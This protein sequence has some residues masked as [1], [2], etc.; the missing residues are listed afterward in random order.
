[1]SGEGTIEF[2]LC[3]DRKIRGL[4]SG[5][6]A[7]IQ[8]A[9]APGSSEQTGTVLFCLLPPV[10]R[11]P[12]QQP[13]SPALL[14]L[15]PPGDTLDDRIAALSADARD[16]FELLYKP[17]ME[18][19]DHRSDDLTARIARAV[20]LEQFNL[21]FDA[22]EQYA[23]IAEQ[24][25]AAVWAR[26][27]AREAMP[28]ASPDPTGP[29]KTFALVVGVSGYEHHE[30][31]IEDLQYAAVDAVTFGDFLEKPRGGGPR[32]KDDLVLLR[33]GTAT[34]DAIRRYMDVVFRKAHENDTVV[35]FFA[36]HGAVAETKS[37]P[38]MLEGFILTRA[39]TTENFRES[40]LPM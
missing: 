38:K 8:A 30:Q 4:P 28:P 16:A 15:P 18:A 21:K 25:E 3:A 2:V 11:E 39:A 23:A 34:T 19:L 13:P 9:T 33:E 5:A 26:D 14:S 35:L 37:E 7:S 29:G 36:A 24:W 17:V 40:A 20:I 22:S 1:N 31:H 32:L 27:K 10:D 12:R 6:E